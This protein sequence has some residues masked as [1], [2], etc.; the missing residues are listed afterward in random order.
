MKV[1]LV[2]R[3]PLQKKARDVVKKGGN[4]IAKRYMARFTRPIRPEGDSPS[5]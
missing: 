3:T 4:P 2:A 5:L 1:K